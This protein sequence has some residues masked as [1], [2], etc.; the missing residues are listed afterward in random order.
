MV[1]ETPEGGK[2]YPV[3]PDHTKPDTGSGRDVKSAAHD[4]KED[5]KA[6]ASR[7]GEELKHQGEEIA[8]AAKERATDFA[9]EQKEAGA[10]GIESFARAVGK[11]ADE[12][13]ETSPELARH[14]RDAA[15]QVR[16]F[17]DAL[18]ER[19]V[20]GL[21]DDVTSYAR[22]EPTAFFGAA[23]VAGFAL[24]RFLGA[25]SE[26]TS[27]STSRS[28]MQYRRTDFSGTDTGSRSGAQAAHR[29]NYTSGSAL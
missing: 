3:S 7:T 28:E 11:A 2:R 8:S 18:R 9:R 4:A 5:A 15:S 14:A 29:S 25:R 21:L 6:Q 27:T 12:L 24:S 22:R 19:S 10:Q 13:E 20:G 26:G 16:G 1:N 17:S 23:V